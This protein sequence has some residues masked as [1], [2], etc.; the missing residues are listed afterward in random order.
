M[1]ISLVQSANA[2]LVFGFSGAERLRVKF[3]FHEK[4]FLIAVL[5][6]S[7]IHMIILCS[8]FLSGLFH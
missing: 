2:N 6:F 7:P 5:A 8:L 4:S 1:K 3:T